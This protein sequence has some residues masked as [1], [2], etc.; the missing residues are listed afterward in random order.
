MTDDMEGLFSH[1]SD[2]Y[3]AGQKSGR[4]ELH[5]AALGSLGFLSNKFEQAGDV[6]AFRAV[7]AACG[8]LNDIN[9]ELNK[10]RTL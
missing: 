1:A 9:A 4:D 7:E 5:K 6:T 8:V 3:R 10:P 2:A